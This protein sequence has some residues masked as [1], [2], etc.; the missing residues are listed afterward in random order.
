MPSQDHYVELSRQLL[1]AVRGRRS[2]VD[3]SRR[4]GYR[5]NMVHRWE[6]GECAPSAATFLALCQKQR[7]DVAGALGRFYG[8]PPVWIAEHGATSNAA[9]AAL[10]RDQKGKVALGE[11][12]RATGYN[13][14]TLSRWLK[15]QAE[16]RLSEFLHV[17]D[18][19]SQRL[20][21]FIATLTDPAHLPLVQDAWAR[22]NRVRDVAYD[23]PWSH[24]VLRALEL[25]EY[26]NGGF[27]EE[28]YLARK[29]GIDLPTAARAL[30]ALE[31]SGQVRRVRGRYEAGEVISVNTGRDA[32][33]ARGLKV[34]WTEEAL[35]RLAGGRPGLFGYSVFAVGRAELLRL[36]ELQL[37]YVR[38]MEAVVQGS[39]ANDCVGLYCVQLLDLDAGAENALAPAAETPEP[40]RADRARYSRASAQ[41]RNPV[42]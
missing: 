11:L 23:E 30:E 19:A 21:D 1:R 10:L 18:I 41:H 33:R 31:E 35:R 2:Q 16:P 13:R 28:G 32:Q 27:R 29:L 20:L 4:I 15:G 8:R 14:F 34:Q 6:A 26:R 24:A 38:A 40:Q 36:R 5:S 7:V 37:E 39:S 17:V 12:A 25:D 42:E 22:L 9:V 3:L